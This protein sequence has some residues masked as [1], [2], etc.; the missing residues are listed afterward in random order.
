MPN[1]FVA[2]MLTG[3]LALA[4]ALALPAGPHDGTWTKM[5]PLPV[6]VAEV[7][8][9]AL[10]GKVYEVGGTEQVGNGP[11]TW[12]SSLTMM[13]DPTTDTWRQR[14][15]LP[16]GLTHVGLAALDGKLY[17]IG[18]FTNIVHMG[19]VDSAY[20][21]DPRDNRWS[22]LP[23]LS[24]PRGSVGVVAVDGKIEVFGGRRSDKVVK[25]SPPGAPAMFEGFG[26]VTTHEVYDPKIRKWSRAAPIPGPGR[27]H[28]GIIVLD[29]KVHIFGG[30]TA[31]V[32][33]NLVR[34]DVYDPKTDSWS[35]ATPLPNPR[36][37]GA[38]TVLDGLII[39][40][41]GECK[42]GGQ[43]FSPNAY[44]EV[45]AYDPKT[46]R[47]TTLTPLPHARHAF[48]A[49]TIGKAAYFVGGAPVCGG[50]TLTDL[51][52]LTLP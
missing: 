38:Y 4:P 25:I 8:V 20:V 9:A 6:G 14:A 33:D 21:Y 13:Y 18:G 30:R 10:D 31:D 24:G 29:G 42:P 7:G 47:W 12:N 11:P 41:G 44:D 32:A 15:P 3:A 5:A 23:K 40:A 50:G 27:D 17:A 2:V 39:Y 22:A 19:A 36:S 37:A 49:A 26:T 51:M 35:T 48:G 46:D 16:H 43:P 28:M 45:T 52:K 1:R 34:H